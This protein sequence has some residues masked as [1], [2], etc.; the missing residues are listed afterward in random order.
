M[1]YGAYSLAAH[2]A[3]LD[4]RKGLAPDAMFARNGVEPSMR[5][6]GVRYRESRDSDAH[7]SSVSIVF[8]LD[9]SGSMGEVPYQ[10]ATKTLPTFMQAALAVMPDP[11]ILFMALSDARFAGADGL[12]VG[13]FE[14]EASLIDR[15]LAACYVP[16][17]PNPP[18]IPAQ[19]LGESY[20][21]AMAFAARHTAMD[22]LEKRG[23]R[24]YLFMTGDEPPFAT[25]DPGLVRTVFGDG[26]QQA[27]P[28]HE[29]VLELERSFEPFFLIPD[30]WRAERE[31]CERIWRAL[32]HERCIVLEDAEDTAVA[33]AVLVGIG[34]GTLASRGAIETALEERMGRRGEARDR[35]LRAVLP[36]AEARA[37]GPIAAPEPLRKR[38]DCDAACL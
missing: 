30:R 36:Y 15:W 10:L 20:D 11:Q 2:Q 8:A 6:H 26:A 28:I 9:V 32:L 12:Q 7:P 38:S 24:G 17:G 34:E 16:G 25:L 35:V 21:L 31:D 29:V 27:L 22:C 4:A 13:Q 33:C 3:L 18:E 23:K 1:G 5:V 19:Y 37:R 14:S